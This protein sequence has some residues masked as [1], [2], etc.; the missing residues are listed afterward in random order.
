V[1]RNAN[2]SSLM[3]MVTEVVF[4]GQSVGQMHNSKILRTD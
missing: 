1:K 3:G 2:R 4:V